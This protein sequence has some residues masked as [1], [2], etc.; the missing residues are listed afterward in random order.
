MQDCFVIKKRSPNAPA[1]GDRRSSVCPAVCPPCFKN[2]Y[3]CASK[4]HRHLPAGPSSQ[5][6]WPATPLQNQARK[7][8]SSP[9]RRRFPR[10]TAPPPPPPPHLRHPSSSAGS[11]Q[12]A[13][14]GRGIR[15]REPLFPRG[16]PPSVPGS[17]EL[18][19][20]CKISSAIRRPHRLFSL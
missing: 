14:H 11:P 9:H 7:K 19:P 20:R 10:T 13:T 2:G 3:S 16:I 18:P 4:S 15:L 6:P 12:G 1:A 5:W 8:A 17:P